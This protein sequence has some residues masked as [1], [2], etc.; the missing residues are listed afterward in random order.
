M[1]GDR[2]K[3]LSH[4]QVCLELAQENSAP[5]LEL[6]FGYEALA[7]IEKARGNATGFSKALEQVKANFGKLSAEDKPWCE[8]SLN[9]QLRLDDI[10]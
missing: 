7:L 3:A 8:A 1:A 10:F 2:P 4:A 5:A 6:F 9:R